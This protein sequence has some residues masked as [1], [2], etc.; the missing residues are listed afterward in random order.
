MATWGGLLFN[1]SLFRALVAGVVF[2]F[3]GTCV[4]WLAF[5]VCGRYGW[6]LFVATAASTP[7]MF[8]FKYF[9]NKSFVFRKE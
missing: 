7:I 4:L 3:V 2:W 5:Q 1:A 6:S 8:I 9:V